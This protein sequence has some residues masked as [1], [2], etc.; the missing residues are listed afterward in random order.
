MSRKKTT[1]PV[2]AKTFSL[3]PPR[4]GACLECAV[5][6]DPTWPHNKDSL[7]YQTRFKMR[8]NRYPTWEDAMAHCTPEMRA[9]WTR[10]LVTHTLMR[11]D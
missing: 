3:M 6:H 8:H 4:P 7:Y 2:V 10:L 1:E 9:E 5:E 11:D